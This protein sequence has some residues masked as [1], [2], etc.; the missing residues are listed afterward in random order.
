M[1]QKPDM[2]MKVLW[3]SSANTL[4]NEK[5]DRSYNGKGW[6]ASLQDAVRQ[7]APDIRLA[8]AFLSAE[9]SGA[10]IQDGV[11]YYKI[12]KRTPAG[13]RKLIRNWK[14]GEAE[15][16][17]DR[18]REITGDFRPDLVQ[19]FGCETKLASAVISIRDIPVLV[20][21]Q[22]ILNECIPCFF[23]PGWG[24]EDMVI[25]STLINEK[26]LRNGYIHLYEDYMLRAAKEK[27]YLS[28]MH[29]AAGRT[30]WDKE[31]VGRF[32]SASYFH[33]DEVLR[34]AFY[35]YAGA[36]CKDGGTMTGISNRPAAGT[37]NAVRI[38]ST[39]SPVPYKGLDIILRTAAQ[40]R[41]GG[42]R[43]RWD[44]AGIT[45][46][47]DI[48]RIFEE[49]TGIRAEENGIRFRGVLDEVQLVKMLLDS[50]VYVHPSYID[51][52]PNSVCEAQLLGIPV[53]ATAAGGTSS[54]IQDGVTGKIVGTGDSS[55]MAEAITSYMDRPAEAAAKAKAA[56]E[57]AALRHDRKKIVSDLLSAY[58]S[59][60]GLT[61]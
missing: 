54:L 42:R 34:P 51:N 16:Y 52:S 10:I 30:W 23:P 26:I 57:A 35:R 29:Y 48:V 31:A 59:I 58:H 50:D 2:I 22:G 38:S 24:P 27:E 5:G 43:I 21:I 60:T 47:S 3:L 46:G 53:A 8:V 36:A 55:A 33:V 39:I 1:V 14:G 20:H 28:A 9:D 15:N 13:L 19:V 61:D 44:V 32:S 12:R 4:F 37:G 40:L 7:Y 25:P 18:I 41:A 45:P 6:I 49:K 56:A 11:T 17:D